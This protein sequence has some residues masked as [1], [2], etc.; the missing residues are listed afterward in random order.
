MFHYAYQL[1][2]VDF[3]ERR[4]TGSTQNL[5]ERLATHNRG[6]VPRTA[7]HRPWRIEVAVAFRDREKSLAFER[8]LKSHSGRASASRHF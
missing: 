5:Q 8:Y 3:P 2:S 4:Y 7:T 6:A 1:R